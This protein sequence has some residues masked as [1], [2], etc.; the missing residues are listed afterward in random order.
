MYWKPV[1]ARSLY[2]ATQMDSMVP[3]TLKLSNTESVK[4]QEMARSDS[5]RISI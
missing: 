5:V 3:R 1:H 2:Y 4:T